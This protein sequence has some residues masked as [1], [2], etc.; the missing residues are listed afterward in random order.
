LPEQL[1]DERA[2]RGPA[3]AGLPEHP[4]NDLKT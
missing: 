3:L 1:D 2:G 4:A